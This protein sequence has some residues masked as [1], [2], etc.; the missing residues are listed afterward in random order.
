MDY[1][2]IA[3]GETPRALIF[4]DYSKSY[5]S[6]YSKSKVLQLAIS[7]ITSKVNNSSLMKPDS[8]TLKITSFSEDSP[9][10]ASSLISKIVKTGF[11]NLVES[12]KTIDI[13]DSEKII[14]EKL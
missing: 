4:H 9:F 3:E 11:W 10:W 13:S 5:F 14:Q 12:G 8:S 1:Y 7:S 6:V 2:V